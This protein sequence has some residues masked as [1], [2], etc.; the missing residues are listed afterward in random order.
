M[1]LALR[2]YGAIL[3]NGTNSKVVNYQT[4]DAPITAYDVDKETIVTITTQKDTF[5]ST[6]GVMRVFRSSLTNFSYATF[7][8]WNSNTLFM[9]KWRENSSWGND[10]SELPI[11]PDNPSWSDWVQI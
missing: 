11:S 1:K 8:P 9:R 10:S 5:K 2:Q 4:M 7:T 6:G 3:R